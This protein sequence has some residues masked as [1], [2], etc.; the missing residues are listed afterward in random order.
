MT[1][2]VTIGPCTLYLG[3]CLDVL[4]RLPAGSVDGVVTDPPYLLDL[5]Q[6]CRGCFQKSYHKI[7]SAKLRALV[8][9]FDVGAVLDHFTRLMNPV[10][11]FLFCSN[12]QVPDIFR[13]A[14]KRG[15]I[16]TILAWHKY[17]SVPFSWGTWRQDVEFIIHMKQKGAP[18]N[19][20]A[21]EKSKIR[22]HAM[23]SERYGHPTIKPVP[24]IRELIEIGSNS[25]DTI[26]DPFMGSGTTGVA[27]IQ[28]GRKFVGVEI[29]PQYFELACSRIKAAYKTSK[30]QGTPTN[31]HPLTSPRGDRQ[32]RPDG[33]LGRQRNRR[34]PAS[35]P[36]HGTGNR[37][38]SVTAAS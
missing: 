37:R 35:P 19:G 25:D 29:D 24:L 2:R 27:A 32:I 31:G 17:N 10:S 12:R 20:G 1:K 11:A 38:K 33:R 3:D 8:N 5:A 21:K 15:W 23:A 16:P 26:L 6:G 7:N 4:K 14:E 30:L 9:S 36:G 13:N 18:L 22:R 28:T 34:R